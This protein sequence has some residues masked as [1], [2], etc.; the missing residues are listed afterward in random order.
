MQNCVSEV[1]TVVTTAPRRLFPAVMANMQSGD[2]TRVMGALIA[3]RVLA[4][5]FE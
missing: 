3:L 4:K 5:R 2:Q 1:P